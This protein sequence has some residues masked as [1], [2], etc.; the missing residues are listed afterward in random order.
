MVSSPK[1]LLQSLGL[2]AV[3]LLVEV[4]A[5]FL[6]YVLWVPPLNPLNTY[7]LCLF[8]LLGIP[9]VRE[10]YIFIE[11]DEVDLVNKLG[12]FAWLA[13][14]VAFVETLVCI[15][16]GHGMFPEPWPKITLQVW[17]AVTTVFAIGMTTWS[18]LRWR[19]R[20]KLHAKV[21]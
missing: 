18:V 21:H 13:A 6:K 16:F 8:F 11:N 14:A 19:Q 3:F 15:K 12:P 9:A 7:R 10:Y 20:R 17:G 4:N 2:V 1:R 5:F